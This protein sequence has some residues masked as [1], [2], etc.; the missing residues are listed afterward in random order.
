[1]REPR[2]RQRLPEGGLDIYAKQKAGL[3]KPG[4]EILMAYPARY[5]SPRWGKKPPEEILRWGY[6]VIFQPHFDPML[7]FWPCDNFVVGAFVDNHDT[8]HT[9][10][11]VRALL[12]D[13][14]QAVSTNISSVLTS[15]TKMYSQEA[16]WK[17]PV[18]E[19]ENDVRPVSK[20]DRYAMTLALILEADRE[21]DR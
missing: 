20:K 8:D 7:Y 4:T 10:R 12:R 19:F 2:P 17:K 3:W 18:T 14:A 16:G 15:S 13:G 9:K 1:M 21:A 11:L 5:V 6:T